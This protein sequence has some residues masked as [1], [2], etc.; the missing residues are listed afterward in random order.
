VVVLAAGL[1]LGLTLGGGGS[2]R[3]GPAAGGPTKVQIGLS[4]C[5]S[6]WTK[7]VAGQQDFLLVNSDLRDG[8]AQLIDPAT[9]AVYAEVEPMGS[10]SSAE[11]RIVLGHGS[12]AFRCVMEDDGASTGP[13]VT[14]S[15]TMATPVAPVLPVTWN[16]LVPVTKA[17]ETYVLGGIP[18]LITDT[19]ALRADLGRGDVAAARRDWLPAHL[20]YERLGAA[21]N[22]FGA[23]DAEI[24]G[25]PD[26]LPGGV[27]DPKFTGFHRLE[28]GLWHGQSAGALVPVADALITAERGLQTSFP[29]TLDP[30]D[31]SIRAHEITENTVQFTLTGRDNLGSDSSLAT[32][33]ANLDG[34]KAMLNLLRPLLTPRYSG[35][36]K[37]DTLLTT[38]DQDLAGLRQAD[39]TYP[40]LVALPSAT[41]ER[42]DGDFSQLSE[43]LAPVAAICEPRRTS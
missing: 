7:A 24:N 25:L 20:D 2:G 16:D 41:R 42:V 3:P 11:M 33:R 9:G 10:G 36:P 32:A 1:T 5:G 19:Q 27:A 8:E 37:L 4:D 18:G 35:L 22:A 31:V 39:G 40:A 21:Y 23:A 15:G 38:T 14:I 6:G 13:T 30:T 34:T 43:Q 28:Y 17:A 12:F 29:N 26:G